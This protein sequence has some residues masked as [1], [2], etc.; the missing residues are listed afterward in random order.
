MQ[1]L[2]RSLGKVREGH[3]HQWRVPGR[4]PP[5][6]PTYFWTKLRPEGRKKTSLE[7]APPLTYLRVWMTA[8]LP[9]PPPP[10]IS[11]SGSSTG[12]D[13]RKWRFSRFLI[14]FVRFLKR[15]LARFQNCVPK[16]AAISWQFVPLYW[17]SFVERAVIFPRFIWLSS[18]EYAI[19]NNLVDKR[20]H[21]MRNRHRTNKKNHTK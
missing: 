12:H 2:I 5:P 17:S 18:R 8:N 6:P 4:A 20:L 7:T 3:S 1:S 16:Q 11:R 13:V 14:N 9:P 21:Q 19:L 15:C 10:L